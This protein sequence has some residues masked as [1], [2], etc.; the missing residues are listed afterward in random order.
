MGGNPLK[1]GT[2]SRN[3]SSR[4]TSSNNAA[5]GASEVIELLEILWGRGRDAAG[6]PAVSPSQLRV[7]YT[8]DR[9][10]GINMRM[11]GE[12]LGAAPSSVSRLCDRM[13]A[14]GLVERSPSAASRRE[15]E[16]RLTS[17]G[18][19]YL[20][21]LRAQREEVLLEAIAAMTPKAR[22][23]LIEGLSGFQD[24]VAGRHSALSLSPQSVSPRR[25]A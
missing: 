18:K 20:A 24:A 22:K 3:A 10:E 19:T 1:G 21:D 25:P 16:L 17:R 8:L 15:L 6:T 2:P 23:A 11:L 7:M 12:A 14:T 9:E 13:Q 4:K 5:L